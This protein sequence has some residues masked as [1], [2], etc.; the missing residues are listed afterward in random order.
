ATAAAA[1]VTAA[2][3]GWDSVARTF[4]GQAVHSPRSFP[5]FFALQERFLVNHP[6]LILLGDS[7]GTA[8]TADTRCVAALA[9][10]NPVLRTVG[11]PT[12]PFVAAAVR[13]PSSAS[14]VRAVPVSIG[15][16]HEKRHRSGLDCSSADSDVLY[17]G[18]IKKH[19]AP[20]SRPDRPQGAPSSSSSQTKLQLNATAGSRSYGRHLSPEPVDF[21]RVYTPLPVPI[22]TT[23]TV[24][25]ATAA[26]DPRLAL[27]SKADR[28]YAAD[29]ILPLFSP[30]GQS[31]YGPAGR[32]V[33]PCSA[34]QGR[35]SPS[36]HTDASPDRTVLETQP[37]VFARADSADL[38]DFDFRKTTRAPP[39]SASRKVLGDLSNAGAAAPENIPLWVPVA[40][41]R[42]TSAAESSS[43]SSSSFKMY[44][45]SCMNNSVTLAGADG[46]GFSTQADICASSSRDEEA[47]TVRS[48]L[49]GKGSGGTRLAPASSSGAAAETAECA[50]STKN[51]LDEMEEQFD[52]DDVSST[53]SSRTSLSHDSEMAV[54]DEPPRGADQNTENEAETP[55]SRYFAE[56]SGKLGSLGCPTDP[57][58]RPFFRTPSRD[59]FGR[60]IDDL[61]TPSATCDPDLREL[62]RARRQELEDLFTLVGKEV[63]RLEF[64]DRQA[65][66][67]MDGRQVKSIVTATE[68][69]PLPDFHRLGGS[70][71]S[72]EESGFTTFDDVVRKL[73]DPFN[74]ES[75]RD[76][77]LVTGVGGTEKVVRPVLVDADPALS[78][79]FGE[80]PDAELSTGERFDID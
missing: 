27:S 49:L 31:K 42:T 18:T 33:E 20:S 47:G 76:V 4:D 12:D 75:A 62:N 58:D 10:E 21:R 19:I 41:S 59:E 40:S 54:V 30:V 44:T 70:R 35:R 66:K 79:D 71:S 48:F 56:K 39:P 73:H 57:E 14:R 46:G 11:G 64:L 13:R 26:V 69:T 45:S 22:T 24:T 63:G 17:P 2:P 1:A 5:N 55:M 7:R 60:I 25:P 50:G 61:A 37:P 74:C 28:E 32:T 36:T 15:D 78:T 53:H 6:E 16:S 51:L 29:A 8:V 43:L 77:E 68:A 23:Q 34:V 3:T 65:A 72:P 67:P 80:L 38:G 9:E 52:F